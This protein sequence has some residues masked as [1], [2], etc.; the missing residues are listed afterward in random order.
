MWTTVAAVV[1]IL[2]GI[3][4]YCHMFK[5][6]AKLSVKSYDNTIVKMLLMR[7]LKWDLYVQRFGVTDKKYTE[8]YY[9]Y[10]VI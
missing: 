5:H 3:I 8:A 4:F 7:Q 1:F 6:R 2:G 9:L 10:T